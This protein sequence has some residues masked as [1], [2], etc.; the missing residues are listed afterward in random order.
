MVSKRK[1]TL[2]VSKHDSLR[3]ISERNEKSPNVAEAISR[4]KAHSKESRES[5]C[6]RISWWHI[7][8][9]PKGGYSELPGGHTP[10][11][12]NDKRKARKRSHDRPGKSDIQK[13]ADG[14]LHQ[15]EHG[16]RGRNETWRD[17]RNLSGV[18]PSG[19]A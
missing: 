4:E 7:P 18:T 6:F 14:C 11:F 10:S 9:L 2:E 16:D 15:P 1:N 19:G 13:I 3:P 12:T 17:L 5:G 8:F